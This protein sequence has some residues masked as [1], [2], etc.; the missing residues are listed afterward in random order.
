MA[1][2]GLTEMNVLYRGYVNKIAVGVTNNKGFKVKLRCYNCDT[3]YKISQNEYIIQPGTKR[4]TKIEV[5]LKNGDTT[6]VVKA[7]E[8]K[9]LRLPNPSLFFGV[10]QNGGNASK[11]TRFIH[12]KYTPEIPINASFS[13]TEWTLHYD[14]NTA[15]G[16]GSSL[17]PAGQ[18]I[19]TIKAG[20]WAIIKVKM[21]GPDGIERILVG[22]YSF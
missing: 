2:I 22:A 16:K 8:Y 17:K 6:K 19:D 18:L 1:A 13:I 9:V 12:A 3:L 15:S 4:K 5:L 11:S 14:G 21:K 10:T 7:F 20:D